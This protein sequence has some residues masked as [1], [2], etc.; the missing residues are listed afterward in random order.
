MPPPDDQ[1]LLA[2]VCLSLVR[3]VGPRLRENLQAAFGDAEQILAQPAERL[4]GV[5]GV[6]ATLAGRIASAREE[7]DAQSELDRAARHGIAI[8]LRDSDSYPRAL[9]EIPDPP[10]L[11]FVRG[12][13]LPTDQLAVAI[14]GSRHAT[15]YGFDQAERLAAALARAGVTVVS[16]MARGIDT[17]VH[18]G[19]L[20]AGGR[21]IAVLANGLL[22]PYP[23]ENAELSLEIARQGAVLSEAPLLRPPM[24]GAFPQRNR[25]ISGVSLGVLV[26]EAA[27]RSGSL[28]TARHAYEQGREVFAVPG[29]VDSRLSKGCHKLI[30]DGAKLVATVDDVLEELGPL[31]EGV[32]RPGGGQLR[33][34][35]E[36]N[37]N[38]V[39]QSVL[40]AI[41]AAPTQ[42]DHVVQQSGVPVHR[43][44]STLSVLEVR[45]LVRRVSGSLVARV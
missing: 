30:Q 12:E 44:L 41:G 39:E 45:G 36:L 19:A 14:V 28:I 4:T 37:L 9:R 16:G 5:E 22:K 7:I 24:S 42:M 32:P 6:G 8:V 33:S 11:L 2:E 1:R 43:V 20:G 23:P 3:G 40:Q 10:P 26:V 38:D 34:V 25:I 18:R 27:D 21:T 13:L 31:V 17:A 29:P 35:A 15:R